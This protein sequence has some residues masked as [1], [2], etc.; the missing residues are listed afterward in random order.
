MTV[1]GKYKGGYMTSLKSRQKGEE[2][3]VEKVNKKLRSLYIKSE[4]FQKQ[5]HQAFNSILT[6]LIK[7]KKMNL[8]PGLF[9]QAVLKVIQNIKSHPPEIKKLAITMSKANQY[10]VLYRNYFWAKTNERYNL[11]LKVGITMRKGFKIVQV[12][13]LSQIEKRKKSGSLI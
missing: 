8:S 9:Q 10:S 5:Y 7:K 11:W 3:L 4:K 1:N 2:V 6:Y 13:Y 12:D